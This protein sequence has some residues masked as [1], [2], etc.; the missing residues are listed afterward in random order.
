MDVS[1]SGRTFE[2]TCFGVDFVF[3]NSLRVKGCRG[4]APFVHP[5]D[6]GVLFI[7]IGWTNPKCPAFLKRVCSSSGLAKN[8]G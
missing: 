5:L 8:Q 4:A 3:Q 6:V 7:C 2:L 1:F